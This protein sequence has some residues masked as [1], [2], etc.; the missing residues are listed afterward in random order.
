MLALVNNWPDYGGM[1]QY[2]KWFLGLPDDSFDTGVEPR[3]VLQPAEI[4]RCYRAYV[5]YVPPVQPVHGLRYNQD[6]TI[7]TFELA[8]EPRSRSDKSGNGC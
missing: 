8:N 6:P 7:M 2:V 4:R 5:H 3:H 1:A